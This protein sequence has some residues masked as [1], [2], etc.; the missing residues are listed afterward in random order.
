M[1]GTPENLREAICTPNIPLHPCPPWLFIYH[2]LLSG[3]SFLE[4]RL[5]L[6]SQQRNLQSLQILTPMPASHPT[7]NFDS[8]HLAGLLSCLPYTYP[9]GCTERLLGASHC[10]KHWAYRPSL[11][12]SF[13]QLGL[14]TVRATWKPASPYGLLLVSSHCRLQTF[15]LD[16]CNSHLSTVACSF[17]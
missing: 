12:V 17:V 1:V 11:S 9:L 14:R 7:G 3:F 2:T 15:S 5:L 8:I 6:F 16:L 13:P 4:P 10:S